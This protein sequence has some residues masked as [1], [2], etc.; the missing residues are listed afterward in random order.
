[1]SISEEDLIDR[2]GDKTK[3]VMLEIMKPI[4]DELVEHR[5]L[6]KGANGENGLCGGMVDV[7]KRLRMVE[8]VSY[9]WNAL[10]TVAG[11]FLGI[12]KP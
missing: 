7:K 5:T 4:S 9:S 12:H 10:L 3:L 8:R 11:A 6:L 2:I 1:M